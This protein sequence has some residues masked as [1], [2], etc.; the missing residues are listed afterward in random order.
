MVLALGFVVAA[1]CWGYQAS[2]F[3]NTGNWSPL[4]F[5]PIIDQWL[6]ATFFA[7]LSQP[8][9]AVELSRYT[10]WLLNNNAGLVVFVFTYLL[11]LVVKPRG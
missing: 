1:C 5:L 11:Q 9:S 4:P 10:S 8:S 6:P 7:W 2:L 3:F